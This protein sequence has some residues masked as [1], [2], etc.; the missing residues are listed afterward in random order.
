MP[1]YVPVRSDPLDRG[2]RPVD[3][4]GGKHEWIGQIPYDQLPKAL[5]PTEGWI[6]NMDLP[7][8]ATFGRR[9]DF[10]PAPKL[11]QHSVEILKE[12]GYDDAAIEVMVAGGV[13][14][15]GRLAGKK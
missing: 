3:G 15:D 7:N 10:I 13:T 11:G 5:D 2:D 8:Q 4:A 6:V 14:V 1:G 9:K 12:A